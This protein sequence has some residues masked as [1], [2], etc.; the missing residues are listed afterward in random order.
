MLAPKLVNLEQFSFSPREKAW[1]A[2]RKI[3][4]ELLF[5]FGVALDD[6]L[7]EDTISIRDSETDIELL[8]MENVGQKGKQ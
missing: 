2:H 6:S 8:R 5:G 4:E 7:P 3:M 1:L